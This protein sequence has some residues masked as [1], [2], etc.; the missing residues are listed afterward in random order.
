MALLRKP[1]A[2]NVMSSHT[3]QPQSVLAEGEW[4]YCVRDTNVVRGDDGYVDY[5]MTRV[6]LSYAEEHGTT[7]ERLAS[8]FTGLGVEV[9]WWQNNEQR[10]T[11]FSLR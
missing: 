6:F 9:F 2:R 8:W 11:V 4:R 10:E 5:P 1:A 3:A 7:A